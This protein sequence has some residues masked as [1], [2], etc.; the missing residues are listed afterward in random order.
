MNKEVT[1]V[2][3]LWP[4]IAG[5]SANYTKL[6]CWFGLRCFESVH[7]TQFAKHILIYRQFFKVMTPCVPRLFT[8]SNSH[9]RTAVLIG[10]FAVCLFNYRDFISHVFT[11]WC[12]FVTSRHVTS[13]SAQQWD[14]LVVTVLRVYDARQFVSFF[15]Q[16]R[17]KITTVLSRTH[18]LQQTAVTS[19]YVS[20]GWL[21]LS[22]LF[23][24]LLAE[25]SFCYF[26][27]HASL[28]FMYPA[29]G[30]KSVNV[31]SLYLRLYMYICSSV[32][33]CVCARASESAV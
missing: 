2:F 16:Q 15:P 22:A 33:V 31:C 17:T 26:A 28:I 10:H 24:G 12:T 27:R 1:K 7:L 19:L 30:R 8:H 18:C 29:F 13:R 20:E 14:H 21:F 6:R 9:S 25:S 32:C 5:G 11:N 4:Q 23:E 3:V